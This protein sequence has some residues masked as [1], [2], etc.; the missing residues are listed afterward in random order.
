MVRP[1]RELLSGVVEADETYV[2][3]QRHK[4]ASSGAA[5]MGKDSFLWL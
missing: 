5:H 2:G 3:A 4:K 1:G